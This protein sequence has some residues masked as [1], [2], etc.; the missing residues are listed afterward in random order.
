[1]LALFRRFG[2]W[3]RGD[4]VRALKQEMLQALEASPGGELS[5]FDLWEKVHFVPSVTRLHL[6][7]NAL[8]DDGLVATYYKWSLAD[9]RPRKRRFVRLTGT[10]IARGLQ[11]SNAKEAQS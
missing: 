11:G 5:S 9:E 7:I 10:Y 4:G 8:E 3:L 2:R 6:T 1:M